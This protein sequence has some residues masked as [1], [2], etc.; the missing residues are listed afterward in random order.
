V[1]HRPLL[2]RESVMNS[3]QY[4]KCFSIFI[5]FLY[6]LPVLLFK[7][8]YQILKQIKFGPNYVRV[9]YC[10]NK[11]N[12]FFFNVWPLSNNNNIFIQLVRETSGLVSLICSMATNPEVNDFY[13]I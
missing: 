2:V 13:L 3:S 10:L 11:Y 5:Y 9:V 8:K 6:Q 4:Q 12:N 7:G 1:V